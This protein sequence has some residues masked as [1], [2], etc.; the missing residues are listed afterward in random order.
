MV[1]ILMI[2]VAKGQILSYTV[3]LILKFLKMKKPL[4]TIA[5]GVS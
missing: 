4:F 2:T 3:N 5:Y 1:R